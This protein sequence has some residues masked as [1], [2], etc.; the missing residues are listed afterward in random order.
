MNS[1]QGRLAE[2]VAALLNVSRF[3]VIRARKV[4][5]NGCPELIA[6]VDCGH[7]AVSTA[8]DVA[9]AALLQQE[10]TAATSVN[11]ELSLGL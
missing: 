9:R 1:I 6:A 4:L 7:M 2:I 10:G 5:R 3:S 8:A 11:V